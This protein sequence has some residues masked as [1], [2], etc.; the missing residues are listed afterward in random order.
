MNIII[1]DIDK[2]IINLLDIPELIHM[3]CTN[4]YFHEIITKMTLYC[5]WRIIRCKYHDLYL[6]SLFT[7][8]CRHGYLAYSK[9]LISRYSSIN[10]HHYAE[11]PFQLCCH[12]GHFEMAKWLIDI[13]VIDKI[14]IH[15]DNDLA[16]AWACQNDHLE[17]AKWLIELGETGYGKIDVHCYS[18]F[19]NCKCNGHIDMVN[20]LLSLEPSYGA[21][22]KRLI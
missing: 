7:E 14:N 20:W 12:N 21:F 19:I 6:N 18:V 4:K 10:L 9:S 13:C 11:H 3:V 5:Q 8:V 15:T 22:Q 16:F 2:L 1:P 17:I